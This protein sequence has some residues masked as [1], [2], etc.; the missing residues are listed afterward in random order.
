MHT[1][2][3]SHVVLHYNSYCASTQTNNKTKYK[4]KQSQTLMITMLWTCRN[5]VAHTSVHTF[6]LEH[7]CTPLQFLLLQHTHQ[8]MKKKIK[9][10]SKHLL[11]HMLS[12][13]RNKT[14]KHKETHIRGQLGCSNSE[15]RFLLATGSQLN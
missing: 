9:S 12:K 11:F 15:L 4:Q 7:I 14:N 2:A 13:R 5:K 3:H 10:R 1:F 8:Q 6:A